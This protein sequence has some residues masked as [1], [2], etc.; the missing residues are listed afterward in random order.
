MWDG[1]VT[2]FN[3]FGWGRA[4]EY[5]RSTSWTWSIP[6]VP[7][8]VVVPSNHPTGTSVT[9]RSRNLLVAAP[10]ALEQSGQARCRSPGQ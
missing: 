6:T 2:T 9:R 8:C 10:V 4:Q 7:N 5:R 3:H 1:T